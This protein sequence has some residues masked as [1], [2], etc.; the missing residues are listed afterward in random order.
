MS[1]IFCVI[2]LSNVRIDEFLTSSKLYLLF[3]FKVNRLETKE[4]FRMTSK[5]AQNSIFELSREVIMATVCARG[6]AYQ[7]DF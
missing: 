3:Q 1:S 5:I 2:V 7:Q 4:A 6:A